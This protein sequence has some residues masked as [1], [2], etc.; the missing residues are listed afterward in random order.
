MALDFALFD[1]PGLFLKYDHE[2]NQEWKTETVY[3]FQHFKSMD[4]L[5]AVGWINSKDEILTKVRL[6]IDHPDKI[7]TDRQVWLKKITVNPRVQ[8][9]SKRILQELKNLI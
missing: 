6:A 3:R 9:A 7:A 4:G 5:D 1:H 2:K 8:P